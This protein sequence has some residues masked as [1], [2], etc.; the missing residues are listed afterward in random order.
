MK[1]YKKGKNK[2]NENIKSKNKE[3]IVPA[4]RKFEKIGKTIIFSNINFLNTKTD[5]SN[6]KSNERSE[7]KTLS[8][9][10]ALLEA[11]NKNLKNKIEELEEKIEELKDEIK[12]DEKYCGYK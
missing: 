12:L 8:E 11:E 10:V 5:S 9:Q 1:Q 7:E 4:M 2:M 6:Q 3:I